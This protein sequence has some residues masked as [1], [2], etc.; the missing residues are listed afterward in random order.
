MLLSDTLPTKKTQRNLS[1]R[2]GERTIRAPKHFVS[3]NNGWW[4]TTATTKTTWLWLGLITSHLHPHGMH[5]SHNGKAIPGYC[6]CSRH[7]FFHAS[8]TWSHQRAAHF[9][10]RLINLLISGL[11]RTECP[12]SRQLPMHNETDTQSGKAQVYEAAIC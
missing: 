7:V 9:P 6:R 5:R 4:L 3:T 2:D 8:I 11:P 10:W 1:K 12:W